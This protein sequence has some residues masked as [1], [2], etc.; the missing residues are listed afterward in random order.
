MAAGGTLPLGR[1]APP[2]WR[3]VLLALPAGWGYGAD[4]GDCDCDCDSDGDDD[5]DDDDDDDMDGVDDLGPVSG[6]TAGS[7]WAVVVL[8][9]MVG[10]GL[11]WGVVVGGGRWVY[12]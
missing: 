1:P 4:G 11:V 6:S 8:W 7:T 3:P 9:W 10:V 5:C 2:R 12:G